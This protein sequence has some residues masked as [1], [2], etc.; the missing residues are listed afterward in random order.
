MQRISDVSER[1]TLYTNGEKPMFA[2][3]LGVGERICSGNMSS[4]AFDFCLSMSDT[5]EM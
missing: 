5:K 2:Q 1:V 4:Q 3:A